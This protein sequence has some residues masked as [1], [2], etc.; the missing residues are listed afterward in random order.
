MQLFFS[1]AAVIVFPKAGHLGI[2]QSRG[3]LLNRFIFTSKY[4]S[5]DIFLLSFSL[6]KVADVRSVAGGVKRPGLSFTSVVVKS[7]L[8]KEMRLSDRPQSAASETLLL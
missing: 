7:S 3:I 1:V 4:A 5:P 6:F 8:P 2:N